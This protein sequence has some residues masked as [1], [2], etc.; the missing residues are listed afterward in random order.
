V[1]FPQ[2]LQVI[3]ATTDGRLWHTIRFEPP[4]APPWQR[5]VD[6]KG[7]AGDVGDFVD[8]DC[9]REPV[10]AREFEGNLHVVGVTGDGRLRYTVRAASTDT[11]QPFG[12]LGT[13]VPAP[14][15]RAAI[16][17]A[18]RANRTD[19]VVAGVTADGRLWATTW[20]TGSQPP[21]FT[22]VAPPP[23]RHRT[24]RAVA[25]AIANRDVAETHLAV[26]S[27]D[28]HLWHTVGRPG[29]W[30]ALQDVERTAAG[31]QPGDLTDVASVAEGDL[32]LGAVAGDGHIWHTKRDVGTFWTR[33]TRRS[34]PRRGS[35][36]S[37]G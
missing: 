33:F 6:V 14:F 8:V 5:F 17:T 9:A 24:C 30:P 23:S 19:V 11:W 20:Q 13:D 28:G 4:A 34:T 18:E 35:A 29:D 12:V 3:G 21:P 2:D 22:L 15:L 37:R 1:A 25:L 31:E 27:S 7:Q 32:D 16:T 10:E 26:V 36:T